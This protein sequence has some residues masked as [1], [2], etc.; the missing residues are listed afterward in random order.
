MINYLRG[1][2][3]YLLNGVICK[4]PSRRLRK[5]IYI[6]LF[7]LKTTGK[8]A[9]HLGVTFLGPLNSIIIGNNSVINTGVI[10]DGRANISIGSNVSI[11]RDVKL[12]TM[13]HATDD[14]NFRLKGSSIFIGNDV[15]I[16]IGAI[17]LPGVRINDGAVI[18]AGS[19]VTKNVGTGEIFGGNPARLIKKRELTELTC[20]VFYDPPFGYLS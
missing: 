19:V 14:P 6:R 12:I 5:V 18:A 9:I 8:V 4:L 13:G 2:K 15:W 20:S 7:G 16:G 3:Y 11:S 10:L 1:F 17:I